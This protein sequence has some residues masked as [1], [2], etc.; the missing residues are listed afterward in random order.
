[1]TMT[2]PCLDADIVGIVALVAFLAGMAVGQALA[3][4]KRP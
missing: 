2:Y 4:R 3:W 1:M